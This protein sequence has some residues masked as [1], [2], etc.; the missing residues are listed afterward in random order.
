M[1]SLTILVL[2]SMF[3]IPV[4]TN[5]YIEIEHIGVSDKPIPTIIICKKEVNQANNL[6]IIIVDDLLYDEIIKILEKK[7][8]NTKPNDGIEFGSFKF[9][10]Y[11]N[12]SEFSEYY[13]NRLNSNQILDQILDSINGCDNNCKLYHQLKLLKKRI[14]Y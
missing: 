6:N 4:Q 8:G 14:K 13:V 2:T 7:L 3:L 11:K 10:I 5:E 12:G 9:S 1:K